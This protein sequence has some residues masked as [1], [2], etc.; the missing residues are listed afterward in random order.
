MEEHGA[1]AEKREGG[2]R[3]MEMGGGGGSTDVLSCSVILEGISL[4]AEAE[5]Q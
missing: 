2:D 4:A 1:G 3:G 5:H